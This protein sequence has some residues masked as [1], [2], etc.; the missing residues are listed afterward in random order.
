MATLANSLDVAFVP[1]A[2][3]PVVITTGEVALVA[4]ETVGDA[5]APGVATTTP[6]V[7]EAGVLRSSRAARGN[8]GLAS[9]STMDRLEE[10]PERVTRAFSLPQVIFNA[11]NRA[12]RRGWLSGML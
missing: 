11:E 8:K 6:P 12:R 10:D 9:V 4:P 7:V 1:G 5:A 2:E 3:A